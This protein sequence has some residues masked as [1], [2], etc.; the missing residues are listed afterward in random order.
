MHD[1]LMRFVEKGEEPKQKFSGKRCSEVSEVDEQECST[2]RP[3]KHARSGKTGSTI[4][5]GSHTTSEKA[6]CNSAEAETHRHL[7]IDDDVL[8]LYGDSEVDG[9]R[10]TQALDNDDSSAIENDSIDTDDIL[11]AIN[12]SLT[13]S[14]DTGPPVNE[15]LAVLLNNK[16][17]TDFDLAKRK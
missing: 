4:I 13:P 5:G 9:P 14:E 15:K 10:D 2:Q 8:S 17:T 11:D 12:E 6:N 3:P 7:N 1:L 16:F